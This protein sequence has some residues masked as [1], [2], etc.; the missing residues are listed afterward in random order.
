MKYEIKGLN[1]AYCDDK[2]KDVTDDPVLLERK[3][4]CIDMQLRSKFELQ[5]VRSI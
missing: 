5:D 2:I 3:T 1:Y 4:F